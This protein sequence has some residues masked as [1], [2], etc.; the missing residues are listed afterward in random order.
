RKGASLLEDYHASKGPSNKPK[1]MRWRTHR[2]VEDYTNVCGKIM[3]GHV[4]TGPF[5]YNSV[6]GRFPMERPTTLGM[7]KAGMRRPTV[8]ERWS[9]YDVALFEGAI[10]IHGKVFHKVAEEI[11]GKTVADVVEF[12]YMWKKTNHYKQWKSM[13]RAEQAILQAQEED[14]SE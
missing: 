10:S 2:M 1:E 11:E 7:I 14:S 3:Y 4:R 12:Y 13:F 5:G 6:E 9:P 8:I